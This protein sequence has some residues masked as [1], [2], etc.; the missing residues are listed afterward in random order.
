MPHFFKRSA[1]LLTSLISFSAIGAESKVELDEL[2]WADKQYMASQLSKAD[3]LIRSELGSQLRHTR[4]DLQ[5]LQM[6]VDKKLI[7]RDDTLTQQAL[8]MVLGEVLINETGMLWYTLNDQYG[9]SRAICV[10]GTKHCLFPV[11]MLSRRMEVGL[12][13]NVE[14]IYK[15]ALELVGPYVN[16]SPYAVKEED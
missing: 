10:K 4:S 16:K 2:S 3:E 8:G 9:R 13:P 11:T 5:L 6:I 15:E 12:S 14:K 7:A 1:L